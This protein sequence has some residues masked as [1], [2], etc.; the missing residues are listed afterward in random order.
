MRDDEAFTITHINGRATLHLKSWIPGRSSPC[1]LP[2]SAT[3]HC[4]L[5]AIAP[6]E[7]LLISD[8]LDAQ[9]LR[10]HA[11]HL[12]EQGIAAV[13]LSPGLAAIQL[14]GRATRDVLAKSC[15]LDLYPKSFPVGTCTRTRLAKLPVF[16]DYLD[17]KPRF[18]LYV[19]RSYLP[20]LCAWLNDAGVEFMDPTQ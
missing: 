17:E 1:I 16:V 20:Y 10:E 4:R 12:R 19:A 5:L 13:N 11:S 9:T 14:E 6:G 7:W 3:H 2:P 18:E 8:T 15:G